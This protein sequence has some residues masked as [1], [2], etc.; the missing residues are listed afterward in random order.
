MK[1]KK[2]LWITL[3]SIDVAVTLFFFVINIIML[4]MVIGRGDGVRPDPNTFFGWLQVNYTAYFWL[5]VFP[6]ILVLVAN[7]VG[8]IIFVKKQTKKKPITVD[9]LTEEEK[10]KLLAQIAGNIN[11]EKEE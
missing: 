9:D 1:N 7:V 2:A 10:Q 4:S 6:M 3:F 5:F 8:L 11:K